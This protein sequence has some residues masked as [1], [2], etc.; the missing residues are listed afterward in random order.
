L[1]E[2]YPQFA[3]AESRIRINPDRMLGRGEFAPG[4]IRIEVPTPSVARSI[5]IHELDHMVGHFEGFPRGG[6]RWEF[7]EPGVTKEQAD[8]LYKRLAGEVAADNARYRL[9][10]LSEEERRLKAPS[11]TWDVPWEQQIIRFHPKGY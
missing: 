2:A 8:I 7:M 1:R 11:S 6:S 5:G 10:H 4:M 3:E 9:L